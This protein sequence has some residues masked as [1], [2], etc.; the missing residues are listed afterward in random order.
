[1]RI[2]LGI[3]YNGS[4][5]YGWQAQVHGRSV[6]QYVEMALSTVAHH[7]VTVICAGRTDT[8]VHAAGQVIHADVA[9]TRSMRSWILGS[10]SHLPQDVSVLWA[11]AV[12]DQ[13]HA[14][15]SAIARHYRYF[16]LNRISRPA[17]LAKKIAWERRP[18]DVKRMQIAAHYFIGTHDFS[19]YRAAGC[20]AKSPIRT[21]FHLSVSQYDEMIMINISANAFLY[22]MVRNI[23][24]VLMTIGCGEQPPEWAYTVLEAK[25]R[26]TASITAPAN[27]LYFW[28]VD[29]PAPYLFPKTIQSSLDIFTQR[30]RG[31]KTTP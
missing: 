6:Q 15:F 10:N 2:A 22:H 14:R 11:Q 29:Y 18:L 20:Q 5:F 28:E 7:P 3:E 12:D 31:L 21:I 9:V 8:G 1:M 23:A 25:D 16:I 26:K 24:G 30:N 19:S 4:D 17:L 27:G 13:F